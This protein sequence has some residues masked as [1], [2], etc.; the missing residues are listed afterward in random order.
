MKKLSIAV[1]LFAAAC[2][3]TQGGTDSMPA[4]LTPA[5]DPRVAE[6]Q[7][8]LTELLERID[9]LNDRLAKMEESAATVAT[10][11]TPSI[12]DTAPGGEVRFS[13][14]SM[15]AAVQ[16]E[17]LATSSS[18]TTAAAPAQRA[19]V[20]ANIAEDYRQAI[21][22]VGRNRQADARRA[23]QAVY[24]ADPNG[25]LAD[26]ALFWIGETYF[27]AK[28]YTNAVR[29]YMRV[30]SDYSSQN[31][32]PDAL[33]KTAIAQERTGDLA[34]ARRTLQQVIERYPYS[35]PASSA[36]AELERIKY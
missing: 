1:L 11:A 31:K 14:P 20:G 4:P 6:L 5:P 24:E 3:S 27:A 30:V 8:Q 16:R 2:A 22:L 35:T 25:D 29:Y 32:A 34:L 36:K 17:P 23:F 12:A 9:V 19:I 18:A 26:N 33:F 7:T 21:M 13:P 28:D 15:Q 10:P